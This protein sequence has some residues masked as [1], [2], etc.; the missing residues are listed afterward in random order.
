MIIEWNLEN[1][2]HDQFIV[3][4]SILGDIVKNVMLGGY[5]KDNVASLE[6]FYSKEVEGQVY[7]IPSLAALSSAMRSLQRC[8]YSSKSHFL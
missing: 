3:F 4:V 6:S 5:V 7:N 8:R 1:G 2:T